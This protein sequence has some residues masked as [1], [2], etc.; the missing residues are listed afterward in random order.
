MAIQC[1]N[2]S[3]RVVY[4]MSLI[5]INP[6]IVTLGL[7]IGLILCILCQI[8]AAAIASSV[9]TGQ[10][11]L[12]IIWHFFCCLTVVIFAVLSLQFAVVLSHVYSN[13]KII[14]EIE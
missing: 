8:L 7:M 2:L 4:E 9:A 10:T 3:L 1:A 13:R 5:R 11:G 12:K 14:V 6:F